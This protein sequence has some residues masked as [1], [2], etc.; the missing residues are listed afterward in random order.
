MMYRV[1]DLLFVLVVFQVYS[2][3]QYE[4]VCLRLQANSGEMKGEYKNAASLNEINIYNEAL[5]ALKKTRHC[6]RFRQALDQLVQSFEAV[7]GI[8]KDKLGSAAPQTA[9]SAA[10][11]AKD[12][13]QGNDGKNEKN[14]RDRDEPS[15]TQVS[16]PLLS[17]AGSRSSPLMADAFAAGSGS[18]SGS[19][20]G[21]AGSFVLVG[22]PFTVLI[23]RRLNPLVPLQ[24]RAGWLARSWPN[25]RRLI[26]DRSQGCGSRVCVWGRER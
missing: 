4:K 16:S 19:G 8:F 15:S 22:S 17:A 14:D 1:G 26:G 18:G 10:H 2:R 5:P 24:Y 11:E 3:L 25:S 9:L 13:M 23:N 6:K 12:S 7:R 20:I 21:S